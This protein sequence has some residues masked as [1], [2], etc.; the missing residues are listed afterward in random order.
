MFL[1][2]YYKIS[3]KVFLFELRKALQMDIEGIHK[4][5]YSIQNVN[6]K[7][8]KNLEYYICVYIKY[9]VLFSIR[10][11]KKLYIETK[12]DCWESLSMFYWLHLSFVKYCNSFPNW[13]QLTMDSAES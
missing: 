10:N 9:N 13:I 12:L 1:H 4:Y 8:L 6:W 2:L 11:T 5:Y 3:A 7:G